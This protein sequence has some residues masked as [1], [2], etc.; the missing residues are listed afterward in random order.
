MDTNKDRRVT[1]EEFESAVEVDPIF[2][3]VLGASL[4]DLEMSHA[5]LCRLPPLDAGYV[6][7]LKGVVVLN[8]C[9]YVCV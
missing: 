6:T 4:R 7:T 2:M 5:D 1:R 3:T 8:V 9:A